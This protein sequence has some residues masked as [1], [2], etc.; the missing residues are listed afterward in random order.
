MLGMWYNHVSLLHGKKDKKSNILKAYQHRHEC[1]ADAE[2]TVIR[3]G[4]KASV[5]NILDS[6]PGLMP[7]GLKLIEKTLP[8]C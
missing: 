1:D 8:G 5:R 6:A 4:Q 3:Q 2:S 7:S